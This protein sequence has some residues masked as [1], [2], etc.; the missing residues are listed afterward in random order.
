MILMALS[1]VA[2][3]FLPTYERIGIRAPVLLVRGA[4]RAGF[5][6][7]WR[8]GRGRRRFWWSGGGAERARLLRAFQQS[9]IAAGLL[10]GSLVAAILSSALDSNALASWGW[11]IP[12]F[13]GALLGPVGM[14]CARV[15]CELPS[16][17][18]E[19]ARAQTL[20]GVQFAKSLFH[21]FSFVIFWAVSSYMVAVYMPTFA[22]KYAHISRRRH[23]GPA[24]PR[25]PR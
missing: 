20:S 2:I 12:F 3:G 6:G 13:L 19:A 4:S 5:R 11:R 23:C 17:E 9:S 24:P 18:S 7:G 8:V 16:F 14:Y 21:A 22:N 1:T 15:A 10:L 25:S